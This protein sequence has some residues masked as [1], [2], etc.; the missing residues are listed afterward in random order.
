MVAMA[1]AAAQAKRSVR[2]EI[3]Q[4]R[5]LD[6]QVASQNLSKL[7][8]AEAIVKAQTHQN[9]QKSSAPESRFLA[10]KSFLAP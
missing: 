8:I 10:G 4:D 3:T 7:D 6:E 2:T 1:I 9:G 5:V